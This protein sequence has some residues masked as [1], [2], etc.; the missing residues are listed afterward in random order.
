MS[1]ANESIDATSALPDAQFPIVGIGGSAGGLQAFQELLAALPLDTGM[2]FVLISHLDANAESWLARILA[3][4][5]AMPVVEITDG[6]VVAPDHV[7]VLPPNLS[8]RIVGGALRLG[9]RLGLPHECIDHFLVSLAADRG[10]RAIGVVLSGTASD[11]AE[12]CRVVKGAEGLTFAQDEHTAKFSQMPR[13]AVATGCVDVVANPARIAAELAAI[14]R[15]PY[16]GRA[17]PGA[18]ATSLSGSTPAGEEA[19]LAEVFRLLRANPGGVDF[20]HYKQSTVRRRLARRMALRRV[21]RLDDYL[22]SL[23]GDPVEVRALHDEL[24]INV[25]SFFREPEVFEL[26]KERVFPAILAAR[27]GTEPVR[28]WVAGCSTGEEAYSLLIAFLEFAEER[29][30]APSI[31]MFATDVSDRAFAKARAGTYADGIKGGVSQERLERF[32]VRAGSG[33]QI[34]KRV[35]DLCVFARHDLTSDPPFSRLDLVSCRNLL[36]YL[37][38]PLQQRV[39]PMFHLALRSP[40]FLLLGSSESVDRMPGLF[41]PVEARH[42]LFAKVQGDMAYLP[43]SRAGE[44][45][46]RTSASSRSPG[47]SPVLVPA[48]QTLATNADQLL[49]TQYVPTGIVVDDRGQIVHFRGDTSRYLKLPVGA[50]NFTLVQMVREDLFLPLEAALHEARERGGPVRRERVAMRVE[51]ATRQVDLAVLPLKTENGPTHHVVVFEERAASEASTPTFSTGAVTAS[52]VE[53]LRTSLDASRR[54]QKSVIERLE[55][56]NEELRSANDEVV[57]S[58]EE[59]QSTNEELETAKEELQSSNEELNTINDELQS[60][61]R[62]LGQLNGDLENLVSSVDIPIAIVDAGLRLRRFTPAAQRLVHVIA[63][64]LGRPITDFKLNLSIPSLEP[65]LRQ[66]NDLL[67]PSEAEVQDGEGRWYSMRTRPYR[68]LDNRVDGAVIAWLDIED[69]KRGVRAVESARVFIERV[70]ENVRDPILLLDADLRVRRANQGYFKV[71][72]T[73]AAETAERALYELGGGRW[74]T[75]AVRALVDGTSAGGDA[76]AGGIA[77]EQTFDQVGQKSLVLRAR[78]LPPDQADGAALLLT[79]EDVTPQPPPPRPAAP[80]G[81]TALATS[82][83][84]EG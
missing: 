69:M 56:L 13:A 8:V 4:S 83:V 79:I 1:P 70:V 61:N 82:D 41:T 53:R 76:D 10:R 77:I 40:G 84:G 52:E 81:T 51:G 54:Y 9:P 65:S 5:T 44:R 15:H 38:K 33:Y 6:V 19:A 14:S 66:V 50:P 68:T 20:T 46:F 45:P 73:T 80:P 7:Y 55:A 21:E 11:G 23:E 57:S 16:L 29:R 78:R 75:P 58:N 42:Q 25:T 43:P 2:G 67:S 30:V 35:R 48:A 59:L 28:V 18:P 37:D 49:L 31:Q 26:L 72:R 24:L 34:A 22:R 47:A 71:F 62:E 36:I 60:R 74:D 39:L 63:T 17:A 12:G 27:G 32:F 64:D 3:K